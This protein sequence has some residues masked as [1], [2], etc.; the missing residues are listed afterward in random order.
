MS[1]NHVG[2]QV[3]G[4]L[5]ACLFSACASQAPPPVANPAAQPESPLAEGNYVLT[6]GDVVEIKFAYNPDLNEKVTIRPDGY[7]SLTMI[8]EVI[9]RGST[10]PDLARRI[11]ASYAKYLKHP[12]LTVIV[13]EFTGQRVYVA[14]EVMTPGVIDLKSGLTGLQ[15]ILNAG[16]PKFTAQLSQLLLIRYEGSNTAVVQ[17]VDLVQIMKGKLP[18]I[19]LRP[20]DILFLPKSNIARAGLFVEQ[21]INNLVPRSIMFP[22][23]LNTTVS[24]QP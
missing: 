13:R 4:I 3:A 7:I 10:P 12:D 1:V 19:T 6:S 9:A 18:D 20:Y 8:G 2:V 5:V 17:K 24:I 23:N 15:A 11:S 21:Y 16:G 22:Y 14:G